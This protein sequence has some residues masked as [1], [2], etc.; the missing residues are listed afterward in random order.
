MAFGVQGWS[1]ATGH[2]ALFKKGSYREASDN[3]ASFVNATAKT[4]RA[5]FWELA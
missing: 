1:D 2:I 4:L 5:D 3:Y